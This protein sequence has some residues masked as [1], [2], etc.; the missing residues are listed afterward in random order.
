MIINPFTFPESLSRTKRS[1]KRNNKT[2]LYTCC[3][4]Q[5]EMH[6]TEIKEHVSQMEDG[7]YMSQKTNIVIHLKTRVSVILFLTNFKSSWHNA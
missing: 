6:S 7:H 3:I 5:V 4:L 1:L 2:D